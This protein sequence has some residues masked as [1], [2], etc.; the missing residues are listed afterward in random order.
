MILGRTNENAKNSQYIFFNI[1]KERKMQLARC[2]IWQPRAV[3]NVL[4]EIYQMAN[5]EFQPKMGSTP[6]TMGQV[7]VQRCHLILLFF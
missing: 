1:N 4:V 7:L 2:F 3:Y 6:E 5:I